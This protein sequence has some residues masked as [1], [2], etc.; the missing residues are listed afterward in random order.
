MEKVRTKSKKNVGSMFQTLTL[1]LLKKFTTGRLLLTTETGETIEFGNGNGPS[2]DISIHDAK[3]YKRCVLDAD[4]GFAE[5]YCLGEWTTTNLTNVIKWAI[6]N[7]E[8]SGMMSGS[9]TSAIGFGIRSIVHR[10]EHIFNRNSIS[11]GKENISKHYDLSNDFFKLFLDPTMTYSCGIFDSKECTLDK[12]QINKYE[13]ICKDLDLRP[14]HKVLEIGCGW[15]GLS[16]YMA[17]NY[18]VQVTGLTISEEQFKYATEL[19]KEKGLDDKIHII[20]KD[21]RNFEGQF[22]RVVSVEMI[23]AVGDEYLGDYFN[24][25][26]KNLTKNGIAVIQAITSPDSRYDEFCKGVD[27]IQKHIFPGSLLP[28][29]GAMTMAFNEVSDMHLYNLRDIGVHYAKTL[30]M[31]KESFIQNKSKILSLGMD[32]VFYRKWIY[33][34]SYC[35]AAFATRNISTVQ[36]TLT[37]PNNTEIFEFNY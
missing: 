28:S 21:Y 25:I 37:R 29:I 10:I 11:G 14:G 23:E 34:F 9:K 2:A 32:E 6:A 16:C 1:N 31:W 22:D 35:E 20:K 8:N 27:F 36:M 7:V 30:S 5:A 18:G 19:V 26:S 17:E 4:I 15:G 24:V 13:N 33:Y 3:F 12:A